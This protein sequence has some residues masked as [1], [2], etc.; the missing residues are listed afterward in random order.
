MK[1]F[2]LILF[3]L[4]L[5]A[6]ASTPSFFNGEPLDYSIT[7]NKMDYVM[8]VLTDRR[9]AE[10]YFKSCDEV[11]ENI[12]K[13]HSDCAEHSITN[14]HCEEHEQE[15]ND[16]KIAKEASYTLT[17]T[18]SPCDQG[19]RPQIEGIVRYE[20]RSRYFY[21]NLAIIAGEASSAYSVFASSLKVDELTLEL[22]EFSVKTPDAFDFSCSGKI[23]TNTGMECEMISACACTLTDS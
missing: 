18:F 5:N 16:K 12:T 19:G 17:K 21:P 20:V 4:S 10:N 13:W 15:L 2:Y 14:W 22:Q 1:L 23:L 7:Q 8:S 6:C 3:G 9:F 11:Y